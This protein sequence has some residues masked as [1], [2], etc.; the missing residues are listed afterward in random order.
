MLAIAKLCSTLS[1]RPQVLEG[2]KNPPKV[3]GAGQRRE[4]LTR[5][6]IQNGGKAA[7]PCSTTSLPLKRS[8]VG[9]E[10]CSLAD[11]EAVDESSLSSSE[12]YEND[13]SEL[14]LDLKNQ[15]DFRVS[16]LRKL[17]YEKVWVPT[18][19][20]LP[21]SQT[22]IIFDWDDTLLCTNY[23]CKHF[24]N[25]LVPPSLH[26][27]LR[28]IASY[29]TDLLELSMKLG[30]TYIITN[31]IDGWVEYSASQWVPELLPILS[32]IEIISARTRYESLFPQQVNKWKINAFRDLQR[33]LDY[34][35][36]TNLIS[37][38]DSNYEMEATAIMGQDFS[39]AR[40]KTIKLRDNPTADELKKELELIVQRFERI[41]ANAQNMKI[42]L[43]RNSDSYS[44]YC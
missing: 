6:G 43:E 27:T 10:T 22:V 40:V 28:R 29:V 2:E 9:D 25:R 1:R 24:E 37:V 32:K 31:A 44:R 39:E 41:A 7:S 42:T 34:P 15:D 30:R 11:T 13:D 21:S 19:H 12:S 16:F 36:V 23:L 17:S 4:Y 5:L 26:N 20:R 8:I 14:W 33:R 18:A 35:I 38:G 3:Q